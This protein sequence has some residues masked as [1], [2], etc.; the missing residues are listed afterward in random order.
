MKSMQNLIDVYGDPD[1]KFIVK[2]KSMETRDLTIEDFTILCKYLGY[3]PEITKLLYRDY[4]LDWKYYGM[5]KKKEITYDELLVVGQRM[6]KG[7]YA[8]TWAMSLFTRVE[9]DS[10]VL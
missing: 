5:L 10:L 9:Y 1:N 4:L 6:K 3:K 2:M 7:K 8:T